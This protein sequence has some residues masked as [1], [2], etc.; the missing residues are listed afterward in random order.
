MQGEDDFKSYYDDTMRAGHGENNPAAVE[1]MIRESEAV[2]DELITLGVDFARNADGSLAATREGG[3]SRP[4]ILYHEDCT[5]REIT[6]RLMEKV[7]ALENVEI[8]PETVMLDI[9]PSDK[10][11]FGIVAGQGQICFF[12][13]HRARLGRDRGRVPQVDQLPSAHGRRRGNLS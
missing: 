9:I 8:V 1:S 13:L 12:R 5:G 7:S 10:G 2:T 11:C 6:T 3:H 4:R